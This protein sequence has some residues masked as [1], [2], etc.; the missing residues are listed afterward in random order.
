MLISLLVVAGTAVIAARLLATDRGTISVGGNLVAPDDVDLYTL[1]ID[2]DLIEAI[3]GFLTGSLAL[4]S[5]AGHMA[6][7]ALGLG[8][9][10]AAIV[11][12]DK[13]DDRVI[14]G[15]IGMDGQVG[16][17]SLRLLFRRVG[18]RTGHGVVGEGPARLSG[19]IVLVRHRPDADHHHVVFST[20]VAA[21]RGQHFRQ[22]CN[23]LGRACQV[24]AHV[25]QRESPGAR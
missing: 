6:T 15:Y 19:V 1:T 13:A 2:Y 11:A 5:D 8:M 22:Q 16:F 4:I 25:D 18:R 24:D 14:R 12:A 10:L 20:T 7:D 23:F 3:S 9:A 21:N 17:A